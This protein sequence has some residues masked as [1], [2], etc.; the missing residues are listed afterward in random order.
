MPFILPAE[1][2]PA[3]ESMSS[4]DR[5]WDWDWDWQPTWQWLSSLS[6][7]QLQL[8]LTILAAVFVLL[9]VRA[10]LLA[11]ITG[12]PAKE[13][14]L[15]EKGQR[16]ETET[17]KTTWLVFSR[18]KTSASA[19]APDMLEQAHFDVPVVHVHRPRTQ[20]PSRLAI[21]TPLPTVY[22]SEV[23]ASMAKLIMSRHTFR[24][25]SPPS[26]PTTSRSPRRSPSP[27]K[28]SSASP[29]ADAP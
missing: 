23:P 25:V 16:M 3:L 12:T 18:F 1:G 20:K 10:F 8:P 14:P 24:R 9:A 5:E 13:Q 4:S 26:S 28:Y 29:S 15:L 2:Q 7:S 21:D 27:P 11:R 22:V 6:L 19:S 17:E